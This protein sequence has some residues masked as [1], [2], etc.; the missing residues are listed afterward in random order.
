MRNDT[1]KAIAFCLHLCFS[2]S[3]AAIWLNSKDSWLPHRC[4]TSKFKVVEICNSTP[5]RLVRKGYFY[6]KCM[7]KD[8]RLLAYC[9]PLHLAQSTN[10]IPPYMLLANR[11]PTVKAI[12][13]GGTCLAKGDASTNR[14]NPLMIWYRVLEETARKTPA[15]WEGNTSN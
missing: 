15:S 11:T 13:T 3:Q 5:N 4:L 7:G 14:S 6:P 12:A 8:V 10:C 9:T 2:T 1:K